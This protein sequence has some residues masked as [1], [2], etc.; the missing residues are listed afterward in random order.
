MSISKIIFHGECTKNNVRAQLNSIELNNSEVIPYV[1]NTP[2]YIANNILIDS[3]IEVDEISDFNELIQNLGEKYSKE[4]LDFISNQN[5]LSIWSP[6][7]PDKN[8][9]TAFQYSTLLNRNREVSDTYD[10]IVRIL[11]IIKKIGDD[12][13]SCL[14]VS[15]D[16]YFL[17]I[18]SQ[19][20]FSVRLKWPRLKVFTNRV[21]E[22]ISGFIRR[23]FTVLFILIQKI[24]T[25]KTHK[26]VLFSVNTKNTWVA[27]TILPSL[28]DTNSGHDARYVSVARNIQQETETELVYVGWPSLSKQIG[29]IDSVLRQS[30]EKNVKAV[31]ASNFTSF[32]YLV[33]YFMPLD[34]F[35]AFF[36]FWRKKDELKQSFHGIPVYPVLAS[37]YCKTFLCTGK[38][39]ETYYYYRLI[40]N[41]YLNLL[42]EAKPKFVTTFL[43]GY[44]FGR[45]IIAASRYLRTPVFGWQESVLHPMRLYY[46]WGAG[47]LADGLTNETSRSSYL[48]PDMFCVWSDNSQKML[49]SNGIPNNRVLKIGA[50]RYRDFIKKLA[51]ESTVVH[52][53]DSKRVLLVGTAFLSE[54]QAMIEFVL[55]A[56]D[57]LSDVELV[58]RPH[59]QTSGYFQEISERGSLTRIQLSS[60]KLDYDIKWSSI[61]ISSWS[62]ML[63]ESFLLGKTCVS[64]FTAGWIS[65]PPLSK[66]H[67]VYFYSPCRLRYWIVNYKYKELDRDSMSES[68]KLMLG[69]P[70][71]NSGNM[72]KKYLETLN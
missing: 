68:G 52:D 1:L 55:K 35:M 70:D 63:C 65:Q 23:I 38:H 14:V 57:N 44:N 4:W 58:F 11:A 72:M 62:T 5:N 15:D 60:N 71:V 39:N 36:L 10:D 3:G 27:S 37:E 12:R 22:F 43:E 40:E 29:K 34:F 17:Q 21:S 13:A 42:K 61:V 46:R 30:F 25:Y 16:Y 69:D 59:P 33:D 7:P 67:C 6:F 9:T 31:L 20:G 2:R 64:I 48:F 53:S 41:S 54:T 50:T 8:L 32:R 24:I 47:M 51:T 26:K 18:C 19:L 45:S 66:D 56:F 28:L 49:L